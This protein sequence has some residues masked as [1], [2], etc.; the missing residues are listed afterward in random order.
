M[1]SEVT[2]ND[3]LV[4]AMAG[5]GAS[6]EPVATADLSQFGTKARLALMEDSLLRGSFE[7]LDEG[8]YQDPESAPVAESTACP[9][10]LEAAG[11]PISGR[12][13]S[14]TRPPSKMHHVFAD[15]HIGYSLNRRR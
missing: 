12:R 15:W 2:M 5:G 1:S 9:L 7:S 6:E 14:G 10:H 13:S 11:G 4:A 3:R 8:D